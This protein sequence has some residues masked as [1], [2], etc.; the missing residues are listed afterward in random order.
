[1]IPPQPPSRR[2]A[3]DVYVNEP[4]DNDVAL[5]ATARL[6]DGSLTGGVYRVV[7]PVPDSLDALRAA[8]WEVGHVAQGDSKAEFLASVGEA[9]GFPAHYG[10]N[11]DALWDCL[12]DLTAPTALYWTSWHEIAINHP[13]DWAQLLSL[14]EERT[15]LQPSFALV[16]G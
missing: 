8:G 15:E 10:R 9:L 4:L 13:L 5:L 11:L 1:M 12:T 7:A 6:F 14:L 16:L 2:H 3:D